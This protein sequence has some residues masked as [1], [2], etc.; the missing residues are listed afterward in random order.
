MVG[1]IAT[2]Y[3]I[4]FV[5]PPQQVI[6]RV[7]DVSFTRG[8]MVKLLRY[9]QASWRATGRQ[10]SSGDDVFLELQLIVEN[11]V[12]AQSAPRL[13]ISATRKEIDDLIRRVMAP[14]EFDSFG[15][16]DAQIEREFRERYR[17]F[18]NTTQISETEHRDIV[19]KAI[20]REEVRQY[21]GD[22]VPLIAEQV[23]LHRILMSNEDEVDIMQ[24]KLDDA[25]GDDKSPEIIQ[26]VFRAISREFS[27]DPQA[28]RNKGDLGWVPLGIYEDYQRGFFGLEAGELSAA[29]PNRD[30]P[31]QMYFFMVSE[32]S[33]TRELDP[34]NVNILKT[35]A[36]QNWVNE[37]RANHDIFAAFDSDIYAWMYEQLRLT[38]RVIPTPASAP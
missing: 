29:I 37:E 25:L 6:V 18:L 12:I 21:V 26:A 3:F 33:G 22:R 28:A 34:V 31:S 11:E 8:D 23:H 14:G 1:I 35:G 24:T 2:G 13:G 32:R 38:A 17:S 7:N 30:D 5:S 36:L 20:L 4:I 16:D 15:K 27:R 10:S 9:K 19:R